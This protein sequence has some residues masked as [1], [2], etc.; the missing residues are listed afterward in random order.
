LLLTQLRSERQGFNEA[1]DGPSFVLVVTRR[2]VSA[3]DGGGER[4]KH[5][6]ANEMVRNLVMS[7]IGS[8]IMLC[9][10]VWVGLQDCY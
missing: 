2:P 5:D 9:S 3:H 4:K 1:R 7:M 10:W 6:A 8:I